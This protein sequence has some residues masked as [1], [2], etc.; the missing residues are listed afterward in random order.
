MPFM[1]KKTTK[2]AKY[3]TADGHTYL[4]KR[5]LVRKAHTAGRKA[6]SNAM[7]VMG[8]VVVVRGNDIIKRYQD[9]KFEVIGHIEL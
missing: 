6:A 9:G 3:V 1:A 4:T 5:T 2:S 7:R 8:Y